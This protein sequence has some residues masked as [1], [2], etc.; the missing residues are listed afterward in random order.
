[1]PDESIERKHFEEW[2][3]K[4]H[5]TLDLARQDTG[6]SFPGLY[7]DS[8]VRSMWQAW[9]ERASWQKPKHYVAQPS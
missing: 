7:I 9:F 5:P 1:M 2:I 6:Y 8:F 4:N 3:K